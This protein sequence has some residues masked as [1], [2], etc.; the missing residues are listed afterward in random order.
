MAGKLLFKRT[1]NREGRSEVGNKGK[2]RF[3]YRGAKPSKKKLV[4]SFP[5]QELRIEGT[6]DQGRRRSNIGEKD[7]IK[8]MTN[9]RGNNLRLPRKEVVSI[10]LNR[11]R[12]SEGIR[13]GISL[14]SRTRE[15][16]CGRTKIRSGRFH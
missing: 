12:R 3:G 7:L 2:N 8:I 9:H 16:M 10:K 15:N 13:K 1:P 6:S 14:T 11:E 4:S 5:L